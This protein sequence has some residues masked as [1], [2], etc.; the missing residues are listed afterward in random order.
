MAKLYALVTGYDISPEDLKKAGERIQNVARLFNIR[1][2]L[3][4]KDDNLP[5]K[6]MHEPILDEGPSKGA[7]VSQAELDLLLDDYYESRGWTKEGVPTKE[8]LKELGMEELM[9][10]VEH[11][12]GA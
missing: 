6:V 8:K 5:Y 2:G 4:R 10:I 3:G 1:E 7:F 11:K 12:V 9:D